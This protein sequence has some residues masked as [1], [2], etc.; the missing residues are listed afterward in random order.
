[1]SS[2]QVAAPTDTSASVMLR[3]EVGRWLGQAGG[4]GYLQ[5][6]LQSSVAMEEIH[7]ILWTWTGPE[8]SLEPETTCQSPKDTWR[9]E[10]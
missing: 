3:Q 7:Q 6:S 1:M 5:A 4:R 9:R 2:P 10:V 8:A